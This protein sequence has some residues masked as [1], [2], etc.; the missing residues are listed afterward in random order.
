MKKRLLLSLI[1]LNVL[2]IPTMVLAAAVT[3]TGMVANIAS[4]AQ[5]VANI[6]VVIFWIITGLLFLAAQGAPEKLNTAKKSLYMSIAGTALVILAQVAMTII[7]N[8]L[9][10][11]S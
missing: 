11:G 1:L 10:S 3:I 9:F 7:G 6:L 4:I 8:A 5:I 2:M